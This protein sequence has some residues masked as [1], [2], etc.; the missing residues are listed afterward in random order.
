MLAEA[1]Q[2]SH[3]R[4]RGLPENARGGLVV[5]SANGAYDRESASLLAG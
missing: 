5:M 2:A 3:T 1:A 4:E